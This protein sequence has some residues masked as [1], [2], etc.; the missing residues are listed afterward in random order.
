MIIKI[1]LSLL[2]SY[3]IGSI[4]TAYIFGKILKGVDIRNFGSGNVGATNAFRLMGKR[5]G[6]LVLFLDTL[7]GFLI[8]VFVADYF[9]NVLGVYIFSDTFYRI[10]LGVVS[11]CGHSWN[12]FLK[13]KGGKGM[14][15]SLG[16]LAGLS[17]KVSGLGIVLLISLGCW[18]IVFFISGFVSLASILSAA[19]FPVLLLV[20][21][22]PL[23]ILVLGILLA[24]FVIYRHKS[25]IA[26]LLNNQEKK[27]R[28]RNK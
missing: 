16:V 3:L 9:I 28:F 10:I 4:P 1:I 15:T 7:K 24:V 14:A 21:G 22:R 27:I 6:A 13:G 19:F 12:V 8:V 17:F 2:A 20:L 18:L 25:N 26:R 11:I 23:E 5:I